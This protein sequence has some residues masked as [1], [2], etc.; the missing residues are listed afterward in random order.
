LSVIY[1]MRDGRASRHIKI[2][3]DRSEKPWIESPDY[4]HYNIT[5]G[6]LLGPTVCRE[7]S[8][9]EHVELARDLSRIA[10]L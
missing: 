9:K 2:P 8:N 1:G 6:G 7:M 5:L 10:G 3:K 4:P